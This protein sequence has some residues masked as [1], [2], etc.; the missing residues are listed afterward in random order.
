MI[1]NRKQKFYPWDECT[2]H[3]E[4]IERLRWPGKCFIMS[5]MPRANKKSKRVRSKCNHR[6][7]KSCVNPLVHR[8]SEYHIPLELRM[9]QF[10]GHF[11][12]ERRARVCYTRSGILSLSMCLFLIIRTLLACFAGFV[13]LAGLLH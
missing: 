4:S 6:Y 9:V 1:S 11:V 3:R 13:K 10:N 2:L 8:R 12:I 5:S 7:V